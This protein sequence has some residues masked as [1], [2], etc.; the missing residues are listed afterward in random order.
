MSGALTKEEV[1]RK[2]LHVLA[3]FCP[4]VFSMVGLFGGGACL[5]VY[6]GVEFDLFLNLCRGCEIKE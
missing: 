1:N 4:Q 5:G 2:L 3:W 6:S